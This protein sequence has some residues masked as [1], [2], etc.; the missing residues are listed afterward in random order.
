MNYLHSS[1][2]TCAL[3]R[4]WL[5]AAKEAIQCPGFW[6]CAWGST[7]SLGPGGLRSLGVCVELLLV[8]VT[9]SLLPPASA[10]LQKKRGKC[11]WNQNSVEVD[12][13]NDDDD[14]D[15]DTDVAHVWCGDKLT[16]DAHVRTVEGCLSLSVSGVEPQV[17]LLI[18][19]DRQKHF[20]FRV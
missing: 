5:M 20:R 10:E 1:S 4:I 16:P 7:S 2:L 18:R 8:V 15:G 12:N 3:F 13:A 17:Y 19:F 11:K 6:W 14:D 9:S